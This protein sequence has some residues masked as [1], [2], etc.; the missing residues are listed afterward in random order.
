MEKILNYIDGRLLVP[1]KGKYLDNYDPSTGKV[2]S[3]LPDSDEE[4][5]E[6]A[7]EA[8]EKAFPAWSA[9]KK[10]DRADWILKLADELEKRLEDFA[11]AETIDNG[12][13][14]WLSRSVD[15]P[16]AVSNLSFFATASLHFASESHSM[17]GQA[18]NY[19]LRDPIGIA[20]CISPWN[21]P[22]YLFT[23]K[24]APALAAGNCVV[25]KPSEITPMT[26]YMLSQ[27]C[28]EIGFPKGVLN[29]IHG[30]GPKVGSAIVS[31][32]N[33]KAIS[34]T[35]GTKT[36]AEIARVAAP[37]FKKISLELGGKNPVLVFADCDWDKMIKTTINSSFINQGEIC[38]CGSRIMIEKS[39][40]EKFKKEFTEKVK[41]LKVGNPMDDNNRL[42]AIVSKPHYEKILSYIELAKKE[43]GTILCG[44]NALKLQGE[45]KDG[46]FIEPTVIEGLPYNCRTNMEEIFG[47]V[48]TIMPFETEEE[49]ITYANATEYG[50]TAML[51]T[52]NLTR[53]HTLAAKLRSGIVWINCWLLRD[54]RTPFGGSKSSGVGREGGWEAMRFFTEPKNVCIKL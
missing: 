8:A 17:E 5:V 12:K 13:P 44:G 34:F 14:L 39:V 21:L 32:P 38:L 47:P 28:V 35:G 33:I 31:H 54:L 24:I 11:K 19:T 22:L 15:I 46:W 16:R 26:A 37:M 10:E 7:V 1:S 50:L 53:A 3:T 40:Y 25:S 4:D 42:G 23:W 36:G 45:Q 43:G 49:V 30:L 27:L 9:M 41:A 48:V 20:G 2:Y 18:I 6:L 52:E 29:I 51:W